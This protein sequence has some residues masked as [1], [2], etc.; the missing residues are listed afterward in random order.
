[1]L[2]IKIG[3]PNHPRYNPEQGEG[4]IRGACKFCYGLFGLYNQY[5]ILQSMEWRDRHTET[6]DELG[7][8]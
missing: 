1:M 3:C 5:L 2:R 6:E 4:A 7:G 8:I